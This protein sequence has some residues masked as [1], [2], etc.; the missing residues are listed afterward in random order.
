[1]NYMTVKQAAEQWNLSDR[2]VRLLC[3]EGRIGGIIR[4][5]SRYLIPA[6]ALKPIDGRG[7]RG[8]DIPEQYAALFSSIDAMKSELDCRRP[9]EIRGQKALL[10]LF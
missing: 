10:R 4:E 5:G 1:M 6:D 3:A 2:R 7:L 8:K 9:R